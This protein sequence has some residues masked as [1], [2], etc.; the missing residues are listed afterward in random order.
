M[1]DLS[2]IIPVYN[3]EQW[4]QPMLDSLK[5]QNKGKY[6]VEIIFVLNNCTDDTEGVIKRSKLK[7]KVIQCETQGCGVARNAGLDIA[8]GEYIWT[9]DGD[10]WLLTTTAIKKILDKVKKEDLDI[11]YVPFCHEKYQGDYFS[12]TCQ[13]VIRRDIVGDIRF[14]N[15]QPSEDDLFMRQVLARVGSNQWEYWKLPRIDE[16]LYYYNYM[17]EGSNMWRISHGERI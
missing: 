9:I 8:T 2:I 14:P 7:C 10:D 17:R 12:M 5:A 4:I 6:K 13:Y 16:E 1:A 3:L 11:L 15:Y